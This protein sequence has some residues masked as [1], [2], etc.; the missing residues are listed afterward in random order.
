MAEVIDYGED[1]EK[2]YDD[3]LAEYR[4]KFGETP[5]VAIGRGSFYEIAIAMMEAIDNNEKLPVDNSEPHFK[6]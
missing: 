6:L 3:M 5:F 1:T 4:S 2:L